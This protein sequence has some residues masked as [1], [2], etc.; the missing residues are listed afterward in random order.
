MSENLILIEGEQG[1]GKRCGE[2]ENAEKA[3]GTESAAGVIVP[4]LT[5]T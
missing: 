4:H 5:F 1:R 2:R 3:K